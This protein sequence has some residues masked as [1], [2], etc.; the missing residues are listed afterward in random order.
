ME[1]RGIGIV[2]VKAVTE[3]DLVLVV[4]LTEAREIERMPPANATVRMLG[5]DVPYLRLAPWEASAPI[6]LA[7]AIAGAGRS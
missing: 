4:D 6:K 3:A 5:L 2:A 7:L 1:V